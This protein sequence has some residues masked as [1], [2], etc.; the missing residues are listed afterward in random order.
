MTKL[1]DTNKGVKV[2]LAMSRMNT[3]K[4]RL[5]AGFND[6]KDVPLYRQVLGEVLRSVRKNK[7]MTLRDVSEKAM[8]SLGYVSEIERGQKEAS[9]ELLVLICKAMN[10]SL[11]EVLREVANRMDAYAISHLDFAVP[12]Q[13]VK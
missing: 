3:P 6:S 8:V 2:A 9:S 4:A 13:I 5:N 11:P 10:V 12:V 1:I 7:K